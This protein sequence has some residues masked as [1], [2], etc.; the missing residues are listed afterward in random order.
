MLRRTAE[1]ILER[2]GYKIVVAE[3]GREGVDLYR[4]LAAKVGSDS[5]GCHNARYER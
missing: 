4:V 1:L 3:N 2:L 5:A